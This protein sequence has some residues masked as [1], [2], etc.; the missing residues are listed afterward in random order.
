MT[1]PNG[2]NYFNGF[3]AYRLPS[4]RKSPSDLIRDEERKAQAEKIGQFRAD[5]QVHLNS[6]LIKSYIPRSN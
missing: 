5:L 4:D 3:T 1:F 6:D 2:K